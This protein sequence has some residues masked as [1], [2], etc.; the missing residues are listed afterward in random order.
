[1][2]IHSIDAAD[3]GPRNESIQSGQAPTNDRDILEA[4]AYGEHSGMQRLMLRYQ[5]FL[6][7]RCRMLVRGN[8]DDA[9][10]LF[11][12]VIFK[13]Y[14]ERPDRLREIRHIGGWLSQVAQNQHIDSQRE[15]QAQERRDDSL[16]YLY[17]TIGYQA[18]SPEQVLLNSELAQHIRRAFELLPSRL[19]RA[20][21]MR[22]M[23]DAPYE[24]IAAKLSITQANAR[25]RVQEARRVLIAHLLNYVGEGQARQRQ[26]HGS[27][28]PTAASGYRDS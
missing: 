17:E 27:G 5:G 22:F 2:D 13:V 23:D 10:D 18:P 25:K 14:T 26:A 19:G 6:R 7:G 20:A 16:C 11:S 28:D 4:L 9:N 12:Q 8:R 3:F 21:R 15:R 1:M 24:E